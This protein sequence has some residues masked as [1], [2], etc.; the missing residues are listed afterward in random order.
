PQTVF[1]YYAGMSGI[2]PIA[3]ART[4]ACNHTI[5]AEVERAS[6]SEEGVLLALG[7]RFAGW[8]IFVKNNRLVY[9]Y[10]FVEQE[11]F[12]ATSTAEVPIG[13]STLQMR[14]DLTDRA[15]GRAT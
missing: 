6:A 7:G 10:N 12:V 11:R 1:T 9:E 5:T 13:T 3:A 15:R 14:F 8:T 2:H 4:W